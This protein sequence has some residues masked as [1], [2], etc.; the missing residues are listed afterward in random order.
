M[1]E[2]PN[3]ASNKSDVFYQNYKK[4]LHSSV[5]KA[6][7]H[8]TFPFLSVSKSIKSSIKEIGI[9]NIFDIF[10]CV[11][12]IQKIYW[13]LHIC[14]YGS[15]SHFPIQFD[16]KANRLKILIK[17]NI[18]LMGFLTLTKSSHQLSRELESVWHRNTV[19]PNV[20]FKDLREPKR[21]SN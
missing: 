1:P 2:I 3:D 15:G 6:Y 18:I 7:E 14:Q 10:K 9:F 11:R 12:P 16:R 17:S 4:R 8:F 19:N 21:I 20:F 5:G 13:L